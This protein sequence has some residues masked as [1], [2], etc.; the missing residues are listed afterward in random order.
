MRF[1]RINSRFRQKVTFWA[2]FRSFWRRVTFLDPTGKKSADLQGILDTHE[3]SRP[4][5]HAFENE[6]MQLFRFISKF[7]DN[8]HFGHCFGHFGAV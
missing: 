5:A 4:V 3:V 8:A 6:S 7:H 2:L 1:G